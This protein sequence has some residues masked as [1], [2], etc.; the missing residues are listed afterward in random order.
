MRAN[1]NHI[2]DAVGGVEVVIDPT[3]TGM[4]YTVAEL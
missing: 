2:L 1:T 3:L 4:D